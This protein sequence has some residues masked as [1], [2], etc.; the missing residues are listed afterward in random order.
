MT[1]DVLRPA[2]KGNQALCLNYEISLKR[3]NEEDEQSL[4]KFKKIKG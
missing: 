4:Y 2:L 3:A 1:G